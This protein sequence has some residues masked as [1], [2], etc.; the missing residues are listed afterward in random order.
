MRFTKHPGE[1]CVGGLIWREQAGCSWGPV[2]I[3]RVIPAGQPP[4][5]SRSSHHP[6]SPHG[7]FGEPFL[8]PKPRICFFSPR[9]CF[10][11]LSLVIY[12]SLFN[13]AGVDCV[14]SNKNFDQRKKGLLL[15]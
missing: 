15:R 11:G 9:Q 5:H 2:L 7:G 1:A 4:D 10:W 3:Q 12:P 8:E 6:G 14:L 13:P